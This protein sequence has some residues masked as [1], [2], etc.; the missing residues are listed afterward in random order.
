MGFNSRNI[1][2]Y[3]SLISQI[4]NS[5]FNEEK[6]FEVILNG[7][8]VSKEKFVNG[9]MKNENFATLSFGGGN[10]AKGKNTIKIKS[11]GKIF[12]NISFKST[13]TKFTDEINE[14]EISKKFFDKNG[15]EILPKN[16]KKGD[17]IT[18][19]IS[20]K[21]KVNIANFLFEDF[22]PSGFEIINQKNLSKPFTKDELKEYYED[23]LYYKHW[24]QNYQVY[25][26]RIAFFLSN[27]QKNK[28]LNFE[29]KARAI[30]SGEFNSNGTYGKS[31]YFPEIN[32]WSEVKKVLIK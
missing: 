31:L 10:L 32:E 21:P 16:I 20:A 27:W 1:N 17:L 14:I 23:S 9:K 13:K 11:T 26:N 18:I 30:F 22:L 4:I 7:K 15:Q 19:K 8:V 3:R 2:N 12:A 24:Y 5:T 29:Y 6:E 25:K 28:E